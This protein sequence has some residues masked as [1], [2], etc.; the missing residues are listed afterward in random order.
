M[1]QKASNASR[2]EIWFHDDDIED[3]LTRVEEV[4]DINL[5]DYK[6]IYKGITVREIAENVISH[7]DK[8][9]SADVTA[10]SFFFRLRRLLMTQYDFK[11][12][13]I[14]PHTNLAIVFPKQVR[15]KR[16]KEVD[17]EL[18]IK[19]NVVGAKFGYILFVILCMAAAIVIMFF[20]FYIGVVAFAA[21]LL[22]LKLITLFGNTLYPKTVRDY[23]QRVIQSNYFQARKDPDTFNAKEV[24]QIINDLFLESLPNHHG[25]NILDHKLFY[26]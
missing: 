10:S 17:K 22:A 9:P 4:F 24:T 13:E 1:G 3:A 23:I 26:K 8:K 2:Q 5:G 25:H 15:K 21:C 19:T 14:T 7:L 20:K 16:I 12:D 18:G 6:F 11:K